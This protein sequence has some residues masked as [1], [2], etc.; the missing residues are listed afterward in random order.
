MVEHSPTGWLLHLLINL[1]QEERP[2]RYEANPVVKFILCIA[3]ARK[4]RPL[5]CNYLR[6]SLLSGNRVFMT[7]EYL[8]LRRQKIERP[9][10][11]TSEELRLEICLVSKTE[12]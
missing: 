7:P 4:K 6:T 10:S 8:P 1:A 3:L 5:R 12:D 9:F 11:L 2:H